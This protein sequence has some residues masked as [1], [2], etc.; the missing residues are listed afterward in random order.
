MDDLDRRDE[1]L[2]I[3]GTK[4]NVET[5]FSSQALDKYDKI[6][7]DDRLESEKTEYYPEQSPCKA[8]DKYNRLFEEEN[9]GEVRENT[10]EGSTGQERIKVL[11]E[12]GRP[13]KITDSTGPMAEYKIY[14]NAGPEE[15]RKERLPETGNREEIRSYSSLEE[16][17]QGEQK[18]YGELK[19][20]KPPHA[21]NLSKWF[22][23]GGTV[24]LEEKEG[25]QIFT[26]ADAEGRQVPYID[27]YPHFPPEAKQ[28]V[29]SDISIGKFT[30]DRNEDKNLY[31][32]KLEEEY[33]LTTIPD[34]YALHHDSKNG[35]MQL[36]RMDYHKEFTHSGGHSLFREVA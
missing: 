13:D 20:G 18:S 22:E 2:D 30:G 32:Q 5:A 28:P 15:E 7:G 24:I 17:K 36:V 16:M 4:E 14:K 27:G 6:L 10:Y 9:D 12:T 33:G 19:A 11:E 34:G 21:P 26:Y 8:E 29:I 23:Q 31:L 1:R 3:P 35:N 25:K